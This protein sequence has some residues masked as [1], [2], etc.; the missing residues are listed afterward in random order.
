MQVVDRPIDDPVAVRE[1][2]ESN[3]GCEREAV[4]QYV[5]EARD[6][7]LAEGA[8]S[9]VQIRDM[10]LG[11]V[12]RQ[13]RQH[14]LGRLA[15]R[16]DC[17]R[18]SHAR[19]DRHVCSVP[20][21]LHQFGDVPRRVRTVCISDHDYVSPGVSNTCLQRGAVSAVHLVADDLNAIHLG[22]FSGSIV[23][24]AIVHDD[25]FVVEAD[26]IEFF[27]QCGQVF[28]DSALLIVGR[29][30]DRDLGAMSK[31]SRLL[32]AL[33]LDHRSHCRSIPPLTHPTCAVVPRN[34]WLD[35]L[36]REAS[37]SKIASGWT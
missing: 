21:V 16:G 18:R 14:P 1:H 17:H 3:G 10:L 34:R 8:Q 2:A 19:A 29:N 27:L 15:Y 24:R 37:A 9:R 23:F 13:F 26:C 35:R 36:A 11:Q 7:I 25:D 33:G 5:K 20:H 32:F 22:G 28:R 4:W 31:L 6:R 30:D 12:A